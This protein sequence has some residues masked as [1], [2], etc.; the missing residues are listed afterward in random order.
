MLAIPCSTSIGA[1][2]TYWLIKTLHSNLQYHGIL[3][4]WLSDY[5]NPPTCH[6]TGAGCHI[7][8]Y[9][10]CAVWSRSLQMH[11]IKHC[12][13][14]FHRFS[15][16]QSLWYHTSKLQFKHGTT[17]PYSLQLLYCMFGAKAFLV[18]CLGSWVP[19][20][21]GAM[22]GIWPTLPL[23]SLVQTQILPAPKNSGQG[24][25]DNTRMVHSNG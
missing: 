3:P 12:A 4:P 5:T 10:P 20:Y 24:M 21:L 15:Q 14:F 2:V 25:E 8:T 7:T 22:W 11:K 23:L 16:T 6:W 18:G 17:K 1:T 9:H 19:W 13:V